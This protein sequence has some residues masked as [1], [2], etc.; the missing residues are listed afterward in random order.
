MIAHNTSA[1][2]SQLLDGGHPAWYI[3]QNSLRLGK[4]V[5]ETSESAVEEKR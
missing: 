4:G 2:I 5:A 1:T 3:H